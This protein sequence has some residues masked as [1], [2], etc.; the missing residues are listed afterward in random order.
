MKIKTSYKVLIIST[1]LTH[2][3]AWMHVCAITLQGKVLALGACMCDHMT[4][5]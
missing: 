1:R 3:V 5:G 4:T 2:I